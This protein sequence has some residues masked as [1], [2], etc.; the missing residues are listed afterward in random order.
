MVSF[1]LCF[2]TASLALGSLA[3]ECTPGNK[4]CTVNQLWQARDISCRTRDFGV[5]NCGN[6]WTAA[7]GLQWTVNKDTDQ[8]YNEHCWVK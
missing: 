7:A 3:A 5:V 2:I 4:G 6:G 8:S 1:H